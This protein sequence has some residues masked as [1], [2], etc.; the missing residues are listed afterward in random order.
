MEDRLKELEQEISRTEATILH[1][2]T[3]LQDFVSPEETQRV[4][5]QLTQGKANLAG[6]MAEWEELSGVLE[7]T[8]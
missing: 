1:C 2:E 8:A 4:G 7:T 5:Q 3:E 6:L